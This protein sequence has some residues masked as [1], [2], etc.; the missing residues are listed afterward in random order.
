MSKETKIIEYIKTVKEKVDTSCKCDCCGKIIRT[1][2]IDEE[3]NKLKVTIPKDMEGKVCWN[4]R[5][6]H[7]EWGNDSCES[8]IYKDACSI[9]CMKNILDDILIDTNYQW[10]GDFSIEA[11]SP[12][13]I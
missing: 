13:T 2:E 8:I 12:E 7:S 3:T 9:D 1:A 11:C 6:M 4:I 10:S 5:A